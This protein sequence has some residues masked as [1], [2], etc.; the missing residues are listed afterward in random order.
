MALTGDPIG[1]PK[2]CLKF[3]FVAALKYEQIVVK[4][5]R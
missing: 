4:D 2:I 1:Q 3:K 5:G